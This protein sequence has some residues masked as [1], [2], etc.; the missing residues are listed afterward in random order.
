MGPAGPAGHGRGVVV[1]VVCMAGLLILGMIAAPMLFFA[2]SSPVLVRWRLLGG[3][4]PDGRPAAAQ[5][6]GPQLD[7]G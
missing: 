7:P 3:A 6:A 2:S 1:A 5:S 4:R